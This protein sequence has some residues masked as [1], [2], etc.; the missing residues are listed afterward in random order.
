VARSCVPFIPK[1]LW[2]VVVCV[3]AKARLGSKR[4]CTELVLGAV[5]VHNVGC[6][7]GCCQWNHCRSLLW[8]LL[9]WQFPSLGDLL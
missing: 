6:M 4:L 8:R 7:V 9:S 2:L 5:E 1:V 3:E